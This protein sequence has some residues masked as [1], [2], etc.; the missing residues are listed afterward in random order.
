[1]KILAKIFFV[2]MSIFVLIQIVTVTSSATTIVD[3]GVCGDN[4]TW[5]IDENG[6][7]TLYGDGAMID[8]ESSFDGTYLHALLMRLF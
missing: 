5:E 7:F 2:I 4:L 6:I 3:N 8:F 1:M